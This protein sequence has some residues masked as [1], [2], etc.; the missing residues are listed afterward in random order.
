MLAAVMTCAGFADDEP[1]EISQALKQ[2]DT[3]AIGRLVSRYHYRLLR[4]LTYLTGR[5]EQAE[6]LVQETWLRVLERGGR[7]DGRSPFDRWL[8]SVARNLAFDHLRARRDSPDSAAQADQ[9]VCDGDSPFLAAARS[10]DAA[11]I[12]AA[13]AALEP[14]YREALLLRFQEDLPLHEIAEITGA[15]LP[16]V[17]SRIYRGL[18]M[19]RTQLGK[20]ADDL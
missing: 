10:E 12:A 2:R 1:V 18:A 6:D 5:R 4:Y 17:S 16:T 20:A 7:Y 3:A 8:F 13:L 9:P 14:L 15:P 19:L 11:R